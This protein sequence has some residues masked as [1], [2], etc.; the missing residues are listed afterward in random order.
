MPPLSQHVQ[1]YLWDF[2]YSLMDVHTAA[3]N[4]AGSVMLASGNYTSSMLL[5]RYQKVELCKTISMHAWQGRW[6]VTCLPPYCVAKP[7]VGRSAAPEAATDSKTSTQQM[8]SRLC[9]I[10]AG[11]A[12]RL[13]LAV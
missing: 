4:V 5:C 9:M 1:V 3:K 2:E 6:I 7:W 8:S 12:Q 13:D 11:A 10:L